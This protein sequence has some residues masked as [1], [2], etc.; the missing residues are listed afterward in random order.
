MIDKFCRNDKSLPQY[1]SCTT[2]Q[3][4]YG[5]SDETIECTRTMEGVFGVYHAQQGGRKDLSPIEHCPM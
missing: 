4:Q 2:Y 5:I 3:R 1:E